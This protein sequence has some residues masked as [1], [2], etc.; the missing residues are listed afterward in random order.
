MAINFLNKVDYNQNELDHA[1]IVNEAGNTA[2]G[3]G[4]SGQLYFD[5]TADGGTGVLKVWTNA[6]VE[7]GGGVESLTSGDGTASTGEA[8][9]V[10]TAAIG[11]VTVEAFKYAGGANVGYVPQGGVA[12]K[13]L[14]GDGNWTVPP[15]TYSLPQMTATVRGGAELFSNTVQTVAA[16][17]V[18]TVASRTYGL[19][20]NAAN[21]LVVNVPWED[22]AVDSVTASTANALLG[23]STNPT[24]GAVIVGLDIT[25]QTEQAVGNMEI[26][27]ELLMY[28]TT[29][30]KNFKTTIE[31]IVSFAPQ[32]DVTGIDAGDYI[33]ID[34]G[35]T[36]TPEVNVLASTTSATANY[37]VARDG[38]G[39]AYAATPA[40]GDNSTKLATTAFVQDAVLGNLQFKGG[41]NADTGDLDAPLTTDLYVDTAIA[42]GDYYVVTTAGNFFGN[43]ATP[44]TPGDSVI[45]Q[46]AVASGSVAE[47]NFIVVQSDTDLAT[48]TTV[49][50]AGVKNGV[51]G[52]GITTTASSG[53][54][55]LKVD[56]TKIAAGTITNIIGQV[57]T[58]TV[59]KKISTTDLFASRGKNLPLAVATG[60]TRTLAGGVVT[61]VIT[62]ATAWAAGISG[63]NV[64]VE[65]LSSTGQ[66]VYPDVTRSATTISVAFILPDP[67]N[68]TGYI[69][70]LNNVG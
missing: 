66:T 59:A 26:A 15:G 63:L 51:A 4:V 22:N 30:A 53:M 65:I 37:I 35:A 39:F 50:L 23:I 46:D 18:G 45:A 33:R 57:G 21:Q 7:V 1:R 42:I 61:Y 28:D 14:E 48:L 24:T 36:A 52:S 10:N 49:G 16:N 9:T 3:T 12:T 47:S 70:L 19:Q 17:A 2:A 60:I 64:Q 44:L 29:S 25:G 62:T 68:V 56:P 5:T 34:D 27:D 40:S 31:S 67:A 32:G 58:E 54:F 8:I 69:A 20:L 41:F 6:W 38:N 43:A 55:A 11:A 13:F